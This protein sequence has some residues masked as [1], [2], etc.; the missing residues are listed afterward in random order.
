[1]FQGTVKGTDAIVADEAATIRAGG[2]QAYGVRYAESIE[3][4]W[5]QLMKRLNKSK[6]CSSKVVKSMVNAGLPN[7]E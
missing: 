6:P 1:M 5:R 7:S 2:Y 4:Q 3:A